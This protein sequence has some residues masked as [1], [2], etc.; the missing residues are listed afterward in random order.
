MRYVDTS[1]FVKYYGSEEFEIGIEKVT[2]LLEDAKQGKEL[3]V[4]S[5]FMIGEAISAFDKWLRIK[6]ISE[7]ELNSIIKRF[8]K[9]MKDLTESGSLVLEPINSLVIAFSI[10]L[11]LKHNITINDAIHLYTA[12][13]YKPEIDEFVCADNILLGA[14][15]K[16][17]LKVFNPE[18]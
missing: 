3:L 11:I 7:E 18:E 15:E 9:D 5:I 4:S 8:F 2:A 17:G 14:A 12:L 1:A 10:E 13:T 16:E 6:A